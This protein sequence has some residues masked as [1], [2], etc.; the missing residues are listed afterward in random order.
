MDYASVGRVG[1]RGRSVDQQRPH[2]DHPARAD[3]ATHGRGDPL[4]FRNLSCIQA[5]EAVCSGKHAENSIGLSA[6]V[7]MNP[8]RQHSF[9]N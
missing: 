6:I 1:C 4:L 3:H 2:H 9:Q 5:A 8:D 7:K